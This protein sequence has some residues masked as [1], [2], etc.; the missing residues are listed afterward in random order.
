MRMRPGP[1]QMGTFLRHQAEELT[2]IWRLGRQA[3]RT[4]VAPG[5]LDGLVEPFVVTAGT[6]LERDAAPEEAIQRVSGILR[7]APAIAPAELSAEWKILGDVLAAA[8]DQANAEPEAAAWLAR[9]VQAGDATCAA[10]DGGRGTAPARMVVVLS[11]TR[12][13]RP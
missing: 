11:W 13:A 10:T 4:R 5:L 3:E 9:A 8:C 7:W 1:R 2:R 12:L 6:L